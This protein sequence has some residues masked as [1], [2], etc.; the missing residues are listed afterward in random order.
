AVVLSISASAQMPGVKV[1][2]FSRND[3]LS[4]ENLLYNFQESFGF[5]WW[6]SKEGLIVWGGAKYKQDFH[7]Q[8]GF[9]IISRNIVVNVVEDH[10]RRLWV[11]TIDGLNLFDRAHEKFI[12]CDIGKETT[13]IPVNDI[14]EDSRHQL[15]LGTSY[16]LCKYDHD[17][18]ISEWYVNDPA[19]TNSLS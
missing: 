5:S 19:N 7:S 8:R 6:A 3:G 18:G 13:K 14:R 10:K 4:T 11:G 12:R 9:T 17:S 1:D 15:W 2:N 16:G